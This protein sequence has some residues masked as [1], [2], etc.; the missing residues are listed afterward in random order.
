MVSA[1]ERLKELPPRSPLSNDFLTCSEDPLN[2]KNSVIIYQVIYHVVFS[3][4]LAR[5]LLLHA[6]LRWK[7]RFSLKNS[8]L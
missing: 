4:R 6:E 5:N 8:N 2:F 3:S 1:L 7:L